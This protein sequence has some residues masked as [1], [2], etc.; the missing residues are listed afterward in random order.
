APP[1]YG[2]VYPCI[3][4]I[5]LACRGL[6]LGASL[7]TMHQLFEAELHE[8]FAIPDDFG[9]VALIPIGFPTG[10]FGAVRRIPAEEKTH[11]DRWGRRQPDDDVG[12][13]TTHHNRELRR[14]VV[15][16]DAYLM[17]DWSASSKRTRAATKDSIWWC[18]AERANGRLTTG[19]PVNARTRAEAFERLLESILR[20][21]NEKRRVLVGFDFPYGFP[22]GFAAALGL[23]GTPWSSVWDELSDLIH[24]EADN[25]NNRFDVA[26]MLNE[27][28]S[29]SASPFWGHPQG[30]TYAA[31]SA[32]KPALPDGLRSLRGTEG[33]IR[34]PKSAWQLFGAGSVGSQALL[35]IPRLRDLHHHPELRDWSRVWPFE[36]GFKMPELD[37]G[38]PAI[39]HAEIYPSIV[40]ADVRTGEVRDAAQVRTVAEKF[41]DDDAAGRLAELFRG[42]NIDLHER[43]PVIREEGWILGVR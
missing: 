2:P 5:L 34:G 31:L 1:S 29:G 38:T 4:N 17:V 16:F 33:R 22:A 39:I 40:Q 41:A 30:S 43:D 37:E 19:E 36:T 35:G 8:R 28:V 24:D 3:Q 9:V 32:K 15:P 23:E 18:L 26:S 10:R 25:S 12:P 42:P 20:L 11:F 27:R 6:G 14:E 13:K 21:V 7:T